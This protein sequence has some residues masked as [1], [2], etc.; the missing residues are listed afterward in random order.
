M[1]PNG[2]KYTLEFSQ[3]DDITFDFAYR[4]GV[5][6]LVPSK[7]SSAEVRNDT[8]VAW[9]ETLDVVPLTMVVTSVEYVAKSKRNICLRL[10]FIPKWFINICNHLFCGWPNLFYNNLH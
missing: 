2:N 8:E 4:G 10:C 3:F 7:G 1:E 6:M 5:G 9:D